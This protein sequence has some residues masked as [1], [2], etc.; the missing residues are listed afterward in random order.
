M[1]KVLWPDVL[2]LDFKLCSLER[3]LVLLAALEP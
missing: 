2:V 3:T 1:G